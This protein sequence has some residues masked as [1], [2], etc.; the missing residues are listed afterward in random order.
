MPRSY[1]QIPPV[2]SIDLGEFLFPSPKESI[3]RFLHLPGGGLLYLP[4]KTAGN[5]F[6]RVKVK[7]K[8]LSH[9]RL[10]ATPWTLGSSV[11]EIV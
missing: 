1:H 9:V 6:S 7:E 4:G 2:I 8:L 3:L 10:F 11:H 5:P